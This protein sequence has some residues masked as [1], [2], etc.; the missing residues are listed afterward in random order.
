MGASQV[1]VYNCKYKKLAVYRSES[2]PGIQVKGSAMQNYMPEASE[3]K[4]LRKPA[5]TLKYLLTAGKIQLRKIITDLTTK[6]SPVT[7]RLNE[8][9]VIVRVIK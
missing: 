5:E 3:Q 4:A 1:W 2:A 7:G 9:C 6:V 8:D